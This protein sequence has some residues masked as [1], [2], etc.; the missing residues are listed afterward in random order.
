MR[1]LLIVQLFY[2]LPYIL[3]Q[4]EVQELALLVPVMRQDSRSMRIDPLLAADG[5]RYFKFP[6]DAGGYNIIDWKTGEKRSVDEK[7]PYY[8]P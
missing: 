8:F 4:D 6:N 7:A 5:V 2:A 1:Q 3:V